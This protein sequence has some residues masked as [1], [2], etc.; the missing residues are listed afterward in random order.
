[1][2]LLTFA[3]S[4]QA[5]KEAQVIKICL[6]EI[7]R[8]DIFVGF[9]GQR[10]GWF[11]AEGDELLSKTFQQA[12]GLYPWIN[13]F[14][15]RSVTELEFRHGHLQNPGERP[16]FFFFR[17]PSW[18][19]EKATQ[20]PSEERYKYLPENALSKQLLE[21]LKGEV[22]QSPDAVVFSDYP[23]P[24]AAEMIY[25]ELNRHL[26]RLFEGISS[27]SKWQR[28][29][30][31]QASFLESQPSEKSLV[32]EGNLLQRI[33]TFAFSP[34][35]GRSSLVLGGRPGM[36][37][38]VLLANWCRAFKQ[39]NEKVLGAPKKEGYILLY[40]F[41]GS[42]S[43]SQAHTSVIYRLAHNLEA[44]LRVD[45]FFLLPFPFLL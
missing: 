2:F 31:T 45:L 14:R 21:G 41:I 34:P 29:E 13:Q 1:L 38:T 10:Y 36:G 12:E 20:C 15:D 30:L 42:S 27:L 17:S 33:S 25:Q 19:E 23:D 5:A 22:A 28:E 18:D 26:D 43:L 40:H 4:S 32:D 6:G 39:G 24:E 11:G 16:S 3:S 37:K 8:S 9:Y 7:D 35:S 44:E